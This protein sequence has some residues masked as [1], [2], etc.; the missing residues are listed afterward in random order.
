[1]LIAADG[2]SESSNNTQTLESPKPAFDAVGHGR[3]SQRYF[4]ITERNGRG[5]HV[6]G[7]SLSGPADRGA[8]H[9]RADLR[10]ARRQSPL[11]KNNILIGRRTRL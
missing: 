2:M 10:I 4:T 7:E 11:G 1:V 3:N 6:E 9:G 5:A 8:L